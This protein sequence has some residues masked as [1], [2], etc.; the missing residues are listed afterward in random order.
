MCAGQMSCT[1][2]AFPPSGTVLPDA[3]VVGF[4]PG[5]AGDWRTV[6]RLKNAFHPTRVIVTAFDDEDTV[7]RRALEAG[8]D[9]FIMRPVRP[10]IVVER[11]RSLVYPHYETVLA[12]RRARYKAAVRRR[13]T[14]MLNRLKMPPAFKGY[15]Y[16]ADAIVTVA[17]KGEMSP[18]MT[19]DVYPM[20]ARAHRSTPQRVERAIRHAIEVTWTKGCIASIHDLFGYAV[21]MRKGKP[22]NASFIATMVDRVQEAWLQSARRA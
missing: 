4:H 22:T 18:R 5:G 7:M 12:L 15:A 14:E 10:Q 21:D 6:A 20:V 13:V 19:T 3:V 9:Y 1:G 17:T 11:I 16:V 2:A 8:A